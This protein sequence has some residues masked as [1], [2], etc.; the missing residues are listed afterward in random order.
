MMTEV[1]LVFDWWLKH[2]Q[3]IIIT[4]TRRCVCTWYQ[5]EMFSFFSNK[6]DSVHVCT[7]GDH[8]LH[9]FPLIHLQHTCDNQVIWFYSIFKMYSHYILKHV[10]LQRLAEI[11]TS[12]HGSAS[13][14]PTR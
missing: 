1:N 11:N 13:G 14:F 8:V 2:L 10:P 6:R 4:M 5:G 3:Y 12:Q 9:T 7:H